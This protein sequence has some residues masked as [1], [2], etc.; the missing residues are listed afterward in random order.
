MAQSNSDEFI[1]NFYML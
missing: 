1:Q